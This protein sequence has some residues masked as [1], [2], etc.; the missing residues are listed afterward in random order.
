MLQRFWADR[1]PSII[2]III[3]TKT[4]P[5][6]YKTVHNHLVFQT[7]THILPFGCPLQDLFPL[8]VTIASDGRAHPRWD[9]IESIRMETE[10]TRGIDRND[11]LPSLCFSLL[12]VNELNWTETTSASGI[13]RTDGEFSLYISLL[14]IPH[15]FAFFVLR[16]FV[17]L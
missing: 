17:W 3:T 4:V 12:F 16:L 1:Y 9:W 7:S 15:H 8:F 14:F 2:R 13:A 10:S 5:N 6:S 11:G